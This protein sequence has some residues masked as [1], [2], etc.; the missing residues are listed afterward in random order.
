M[1]TDTHK[2]ILH[3]AFTSGQKNASAVKPE[4]GCNISDMTAELEP[5]FNNVPS[6]LAELARMIPNDIAVSDPDE[7]LT[8]GELDQ[9]VDEIWRGLLGT[10]IFGITDDFVQ[11]GGHSSTGE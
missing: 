7:T 4:F 1:N 9:R 11:I 2:A 3:T 8:F 10:D 5:R 6:R